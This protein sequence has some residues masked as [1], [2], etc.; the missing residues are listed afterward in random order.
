LL[1]AAAALYVADAVPDI[2]EGLT[3][4]ATII[5]SGQAFARFED[6]RAATRRSA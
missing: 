3:V 1:N 5:D 6:Y 2:A 4:A